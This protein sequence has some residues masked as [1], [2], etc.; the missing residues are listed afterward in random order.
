MLLGG[1]PQTSGDVLA[2]LRRTRTIAHSTVTTTLARLYEQGLLIRT[3]TPGRTKPRRY[4]ARYPSRGALLAGT[5]EALCT[6]LEADRGD[7]AE[8]L[9]VLLGAPR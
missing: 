1:R 2:T 3:A 5:I 4:T 8:A 7:R 6:H 9:A